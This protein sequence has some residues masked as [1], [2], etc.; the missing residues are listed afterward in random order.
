MLGLL[1]SDEDEDEGEDDGG[2]GGEDLP[3]ATTALVGDRAAAP[4]PSA[5]GQSAAERGVA[6]GEGEDTEAAAVRLMT[7]RAQLA[8]RRRIELEQQLVASGQRASAVRGRNYPAQS[9]RAPLHS[10]RGTGPPNPP[11]RSRAALGGG[12]VQGAGAGPAAQGRHA[13]RLAGATA[14]ARERGFRAA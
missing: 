14:G 2:E 8:P 12:G 9:A 10:P 4:A 7:E 5:P 11:S 6:G 3:L 13:A 1:P